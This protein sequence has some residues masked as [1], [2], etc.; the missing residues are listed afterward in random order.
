LINSG[1]SSNNLILLSTTSG[2][3]LTFN[4]LNTGVGSQIVGVA[5][6]LYI[7]TNN[8]ERMRITSAGNVGIGTTSPSNTLHVKSTATGNTS[9]FE[10]P[11]ASDSFIN[12]TNTGV[13]NTYIGFNNS[14]ATN[15]VGI[16][17][18]TSYLANANAYPFAFST[19][20]VE[21]MRITSSGNVG[22]GTTSPTLNGVVTI[23]QRSASGDGSNTLTL[24]HFNANNNYI[25][26]GW[27]GTSLGSINQKDGSQIVFNAPNG[28]FLNTTGGNV[29]IGTTS[30]A[31]K[32]DVIGNLRLLVNNEAV[33]FQSVD[34]NGNYITMHNGSGGYGY[35]GSNFHLIG[36]GS[37]SD[38]GIRGESNLVFSSGGA[39][40]RMR[41]TSSGNVGIGTTSP[42]EK[43][44]VQNGGSGAKIKVSNSAGGYASLEC[45]SNATS[46]AQLNFTNQL[47]LIGGNVGI[48]TTSPTAKLHV[49][50][51]VEYATNA[52]AIAGGLTVG[53]FYHTGGVVKVV[54]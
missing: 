19:S 26:F 17:T 10:G 50:G 13:S 8:S 6:D 42:S 14:G 34:S 23:A 29:G 28:L 24:N 5:N 18:G 32:L 39:V 20:N 47:S 2:V 35:I 41:I 48:G 45:S 12:I 21:R 11:G 15:S 38:L 22:I 52:L 31:Y 9:Q 36:G 43:L 1:N 53:A 54:I 25:N 49:V 46:V 30:P 37:A 16:T 3:N 40:E 4:D 51:M 33:R 27:Y 44:E 7:S